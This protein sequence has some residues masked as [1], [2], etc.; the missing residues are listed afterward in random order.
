MLLRFLLLLFIALSC[1]CRSN[2]PQTRDSVRLNLH[3]EPPSLDLRKAT[4]S[5]SISIIKMLFEGLCNVDEQGKITPAIASSWEISED[6]LTYTFHLKKTLW[7]DGSTLTA[8]HFADSFFS[9]LDPLFP[10]ENAGQLYIIKNAKA[11]KEGKIAKEAVGIEV[12]NDYCLKLCLNYPAP[13]FL[14]LLSQ[15]P[16]FPLKEGNTA[17]SNGA[18]ILN[19]YKLRDRIV[20]KKNSNYWNAKEVKLNELLFYMIEDGMA[21]LALFE[22][23]RLD[24]AGSP[25]STLPIDALE[26]IKQNKNLKLTTYNVAGVYYYVFNTKRPPF[27]DLHVRRAFAFSINR[28]SIID[29]ILQGGQTPALS[30]VPK[31]LYKENNYIP[32]FEDDA[33]AK[34]KKELALS[35]YAK[36]LPKIQLIYNTLESH[37]KIAQTIEQ[38]WK[39]GLKAS[40]TLSNK[41]W[42]VYLDDLKKREFQV[43]RMAGVAICEDPSDFLESFI[44]ASHPRNMTGWE[45]AQFTKLIEQANGQTDEAARMELFHK[46]EKILIDEMPIAPIYFYTF[47]YLKNPKLQGVMLSP[48]GDIDLRYAYW[49]ESE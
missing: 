49:E 45:N 22:D 20:L 35:K 36:K 10:S 38:Q 46:A 15:P 44:S 43:A 37:H 19:S 31:L 1:G 48:L 24:F 34:A 25:L 14:T 9:T 39:N 18:F 40:V 21:E 47:S 12:V 33:I 26:Q 3:S 2:R 8:H 16:F 6:K 7:C 11:F 32:L 28:Q 29:H 17:I 30:F 42:K 13:Y 23:G 41:E 4:D 27:D 5:T